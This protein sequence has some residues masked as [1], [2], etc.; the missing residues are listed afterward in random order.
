MSVAQSLTAAGWD[1]TGLQQSRIAIPKRFTAPMREMLSL[2]PR[3]EVTNGRRALRLLEHRRFRA[4]YD[5]FV[6][7]AEVG[8]A[9]PAIA[10]F[11]TDVQTRSG[12]ERE[13]AFDLKTSAGKPKRKRRRRKCRPAS[14]DS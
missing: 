6:L 10:K 8:E 2:Q 4:A 1:I 14:S 3:F 13:E 12:D 9:D 11:W 7:R 5:F